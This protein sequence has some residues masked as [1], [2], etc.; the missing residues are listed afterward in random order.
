MWKL[1]KSELKNVKTKEIWIKRGL[2][3]IIMYQ[4][5]F[6]NCDKC[7]ILKSDVN[8]GKQ[9]RVYR[10]YLYC[11]HKFSVNLDLF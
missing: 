3:L 9:Y 10:N 5:W 11:L 8:N 6:N 4:Y 1:R 2:C 7:A